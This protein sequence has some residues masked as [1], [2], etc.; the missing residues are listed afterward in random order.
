MD[1]EAVLDALAERLRDDPVGVF[2]AIAATLPKEVDIRT[3]PQ[4]HHLILLRLVGQAQERGIDL[5]ALL[6]P[7]TIEGASL[8][9][10]GLPE[11]LR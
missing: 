9:E 3:E 11:W 1:P 5:H 10:D 8:T 6:E 4:T 7:P 2:K